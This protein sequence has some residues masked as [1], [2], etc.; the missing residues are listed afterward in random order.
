MIYEYRATVEWYWQGNSKNSEQ[1][2]SQCHVAHHIA[3]HIAHH[4]SHMDCSEREPGPP[5]WEVG[6]KPP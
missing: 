5:L 6:G 1:T 4:K 2:L 3:H